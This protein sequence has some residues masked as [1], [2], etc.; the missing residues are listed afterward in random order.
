MQLVWA[1]FIWFFMK[2]S[3]SLK[4]AIMAIKSFIGHCSGHLQSHVIVYEVP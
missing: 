4:N 1:R 3:L 2:Y